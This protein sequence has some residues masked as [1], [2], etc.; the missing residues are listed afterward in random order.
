MIHLHR[1]LTQALPL[2]GTRRL[3]DGPTTAEL[4]LEAQFT[5]ALIP[6]LETSYRYPLRNGLEALPDVTEAQ[7]REYLAADLA[8]DAATAVL[9]FVLLQ[10]LQRGVNV[11]GQMALIELGLDGR[12]ALSNPGIIA[13]IERFARRLVSRGGALSLVQTTAAE[14]A[15]QITSMRAAGLSALAM[16]AGLGVWMGGRVVSRSANIAAT[17]AIRATRGGLG[18]T[19]GRNGI[20][21][22]IHRT[23][24][25]AC[26]LCGPLEGERYPVA[27]GFVVGAIP[28]H[29]FCRCWYEPDTAEWTE[30]EEIWYGQ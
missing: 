13:E 2:A 27:G 1:T 8:S 18:M 29:N 7:L 5:E 23:L 6:A 26:P 16:T 30:P 20:P 14:L 22:M 17:E 10:N 25:D 19:F 28:V 3:S 11:G 12:F 24:E 15:R 21:F 9:L 4:T